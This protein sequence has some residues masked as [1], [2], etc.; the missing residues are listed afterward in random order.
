MSALPNFSLYAKEIPAA[1]ADFGAV[2]IQE[3]TVPLSEFRGKNVR[4]SLRS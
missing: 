4:L 2:P 1:H 3:I